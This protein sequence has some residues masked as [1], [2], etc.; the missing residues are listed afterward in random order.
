LN[1]F[2]VNKKRNVTA[3]TMVFFF[4]SFNAD[5]THFF[6]IQTVERNQVLISLLLKN[7]VSCL[8]RKIKNTQK[9]MFYPFTKKKKKKKKERKKEKENL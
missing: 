5:M 6:L 7:R 4:W 8:H 9:S 2:K 3:F 1:R